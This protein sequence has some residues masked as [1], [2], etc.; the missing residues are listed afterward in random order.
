[1]GPF[2]GVLMDRDELSFGSMTTDE[3]FAARQL[4]RRDVR[5]WHLR[6][7]RLIAE[8]TALIMIAV[9][10]GALAFLAT[11]YWGGWVVAVLYMGVLALVVILSRRDVLPDSRFDRWTVELPALREYIRMH[12]RS[13]RLI[14]QVL[15]ERRR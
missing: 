5:A 11:E 13:L 12:R 7:W 15:T 1:V 3:L 8:A 4:R 10:L 6:R 2:D 14:D 9:A